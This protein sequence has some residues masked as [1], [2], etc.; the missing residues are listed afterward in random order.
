MQREVKGTRPISN[1]IFYR[2]VLGREV[3]PVT[4][5]SGPH[6]GKA[7]KTLTRICRGGETTFVL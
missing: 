5:L 3:L 4:R 7:S 1:C 2:N 6:A